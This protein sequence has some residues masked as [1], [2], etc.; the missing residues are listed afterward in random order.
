WAR[1]ARQPQK[2]FRLDADNRESR[3]VDRNFSPRNGRV[4]CEPFFPIAEAHHASRI[5]AFSIVVVDQLPTERRHNSERA[6]AIS[7]NRFRLRDLCR[8]V[9]HHTN[10]FHF[11]E[12]EYIRE[13]LGFLKP[14]EHWKRE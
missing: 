7:G 9:R 3:A 5:C 13:R 10:G 4:R 2:F 11:G 8:A 12:S 6:V 14:L 1:A